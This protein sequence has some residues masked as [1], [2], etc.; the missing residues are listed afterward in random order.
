MNNDDRTESGHFKKGQSGNPAGR[1]RGI[2]AKRRTRAEIDDD[3][4]TDFLVEALTLPQVADSQAY[5]AHVGFALPET[6]DTRALLE[7]WR[8]HYRR[9]DGSLDVDRALEDFSTSPMIRNRVAEIRAEHEV[10]D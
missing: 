3:Q 7:A 2:K 8:N 10:N 6:L 9:P 4:I 5:F 1:P